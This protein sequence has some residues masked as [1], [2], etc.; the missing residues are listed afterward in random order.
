GALSEGV[1]RAYGIA[2]ARTARIGRRAGQDSRHA[3]RSAQART[4]FSSEPAA[5]ER[6]VRQ[7]VA[8]SVFSSFLF[9]AL[10][11]YATVLHP[12][13]GASIFAWRVILALPVLALLI[14]RARDWGAIHAMHRRLGQEWSLWRTLIVSALLIGV[15]L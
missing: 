3:D 13:S 6:G 9:A 4:P 10:Y 15:R 11:Y 7:G 1:P 2:A 14:S 5:R 12:L 8:L